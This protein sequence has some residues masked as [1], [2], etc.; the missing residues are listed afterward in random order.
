M[1]P[2]EMIGSVMCILAA[3]GTI[4]AAEKQFLQRLCRQ[5]HIPGNIVQAA[6]EDVKQGK[7][8]IAVPDTAKEQQ[9]L[10]RVLVQAAQAD[11][12]T[13]TQE[14]TMLNAVAAKFGISAT[15]LDQ[16][17]A[18][19]EKPSP[20]KTTSSEAP[21]APAP[22]KPSSG[23]LMTCPKCAVEQPEALRCQHCGIFIKSYHKQQR[24]EQQESSQ[25]HAPILLYA[26]SGTLTIYAVPFGLIMGLITAAGV[27]WLYQLLITW[28]PLIYLNA[29]ATLI[30]G[31]VIGLAVGLG[32]QF[33]KCRN[34]WLGVVLAFIA[35]AIGDGLT[36]WYAY[37]DIESILA[38]V[39][40]G[41]T[42]SKFGL[43][44]GIP[45]QGPAVYVFWGVEFILLCGAAMAAATIGP[46][47]PF[48]EKCQQWTKKHHLG[49]IAGIDEAYLLKALHEDN[50]RPFLQPPPQASWKTVSYDLYSCPRC[51][52]SRF[53]TVAVEWDDEGQKQEE[54]VLYYALVTL[55]Q[56]AELRET[57]KQYRNRDV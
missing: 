1:T 10:F 6:F 51:R 2:G 18:T 9:Q 39:E 56:I 24:K 17:F 44:V 8:R 57:L 4:N 22:P 48:C 27:G 15:A 21:P 34:V 16:Y 41:W 12:T 29:L 13:G 7:G 28:N 46:G 36:F 3:D 5:Y 20:E 35:A 38:Q 30:Y 14:R 25:D 52:K 11:G 37:S 54:I 55:E 43:P 33:G 19:K 50:L 47:E 53:L 45:L 26:P 40:I 42:I 49:K 31:V 23:P 32:L